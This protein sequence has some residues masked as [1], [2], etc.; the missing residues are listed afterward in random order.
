MFKFCSETA[1]N[2]FVYSLFLK[3]YIVK[4]QKS[5]L[6]LQFLHLKSRVMI[7]GPLERIDIFLAA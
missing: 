4:S 3:A 2:S 5:E 6:L 1:A 7:S